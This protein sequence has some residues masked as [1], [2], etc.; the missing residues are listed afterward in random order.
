MR[1]H[2][3]GEDVAVLVDQPLMRRAAGSPALQ[4]LVE[5]VGV[6]LVL[7]G[8]ARVDDLQLAGGNAEQLHVARH[9]LVA[10][11]QDGLAQFLRLE[12]P[13]G[14]DDGRLLALGEDDALLLLARTLP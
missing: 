7:V 4:A 13:G 2:G 1:H 5:E 11:D 10:A 3:G 6:G 8:D 12:L 9:L 14:A